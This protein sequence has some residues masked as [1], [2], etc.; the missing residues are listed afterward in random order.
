MK[1][2]LCNRRAASRG[3][4]A[5]EFALVFPILFLMMY[6]MLSYALIFAAQHSLSDAAAEAGRIA[7][8]FT[9]DMEKDKNAILRGQNGC[10]AVVHRVEWVTKMGGGNTSCQVSNYTASCPAVHDKSQCISVVM[11]YNYAAHPL[12]PKLPLL[13]LPAQ[14]TGQAITQI[15]LKY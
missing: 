9:N 8:R 3:A 15:A 14:L 6:G 7:V 2:P 1:N 5:L 11:S 13:P 4:A 12:L 10:S